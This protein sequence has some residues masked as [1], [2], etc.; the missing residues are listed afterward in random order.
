MISSPFKIKERYRITKVLKE[1]MRRSF[2]YFTAIRLLNPHGKNHTFAVVVSKKVAAAA[3]K[4]NRIRRRLYEGLR[5]GLS[6]PSLTSP[7]SA[8][9]D[10]II[11]GKPSVL[12]APFDLIQSDITS[13]IR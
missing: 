4:R 3:V 11:L 8:C 1:G 2:S 7:A 12:A 10:V 9:Y 5:L 13:L 6:A